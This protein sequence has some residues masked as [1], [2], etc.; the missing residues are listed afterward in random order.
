MA[1][2]APVD[3]LSV[4]FAIGLAA[5]FLGERFTLRQALG[6]ALIVGGVMLFALEKPAA[7]LPKAAISQ[8]AQK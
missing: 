4:V 6:T 1:Q 5:L 8:S 7:S 3:K 2:V